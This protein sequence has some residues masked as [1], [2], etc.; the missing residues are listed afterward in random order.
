[1]I[2]P[3]QSMFNRVW[4]EKS[5][6]LSKITI[7]LNVKKDSEFDVQWYCDLLEDA[8][9]ELV[10]APQRQFY[11]EIKYTADGF[12]NKLDEWEEPKMEIDEPIKVQNIVPIKSS[13]LP[14]LDEFFE[15]EEISRW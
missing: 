6:T 14:E 4:N 11:G 12:L 13:P 3:G 8:L 2:E 5:R 7:D 1:M 10:E 15:S 9:L